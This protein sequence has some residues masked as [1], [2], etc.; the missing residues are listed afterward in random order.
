M[1]GFY[2]GTDLANK[3]FYGFKLTHATGDFN[4]D[5]INDGSTV[6]LPQQGYIVGPNEYI[7]WIWSTGA[8]QFRWG[9]KGHLEMVLI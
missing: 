6:S 5:V 4:V 1:S 2:E 7:N 3:T 9:N 8:Y